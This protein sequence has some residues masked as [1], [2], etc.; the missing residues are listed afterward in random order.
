MA[1][2]DFVQRFAPARHHGYLPIHI[3][4]LVL[5]LLALFNTP[6][7]RVGKHNLFFAMQQ[8]MRL[9]H[10]MS[11]GRCGRHGVHQARLGVHAY[12]NTKGLPASRQ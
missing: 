7:T 9:R 11:I 3:S 5:N 12:V 10:V 8:S 1:G 2:F 6:V 4:V